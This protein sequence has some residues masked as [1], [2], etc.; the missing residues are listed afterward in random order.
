LQYLLLI[1]LVLLILSLL[2]SEDV[3]MG[4][5]LKKLTVDTSAEGIH[6]VTDKLK[7]AGIRY[8]FVTV[9]SRGSIGSSADAGAY[10]KSNIAMYKFGEKPG[11][12]YYVF[13]S[14]KNYPRAKDLIAQT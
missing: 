6:K 14:R 4:I 3:I 11:M 7:E 10:A 8:Q 2:L 13:V 1:P 12:V 5:F 9:R